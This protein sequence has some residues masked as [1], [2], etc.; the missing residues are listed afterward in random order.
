MLL[1]GIQ[2]LDLEEEEEE[3]EEEENWFLTASLEIFYA[4]SLE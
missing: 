3:E 4:F 2:F 1:G